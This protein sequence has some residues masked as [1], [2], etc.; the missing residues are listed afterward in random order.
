MPTFYER[1]STAKADF[2]KCKPLFSADLLTKLNKGANLGP[3]LKTFDKA[4]GYEAR[5]KAMMPVR[6]AKEVYDR[7]IRV[8]MKVIVDAKKKD[9]PAYKALEKLEKSLLSILVDADKKAQPPRPGGGTV[10]YEV[11]RSFN[12]AGSFKPKYLDLQTTRVDVVIEVDKTLDELIKNGQESLKIE[13]LG[14]VAKEELVKVGDVFAKTVAAIDDKVKD[15]NAAGRETKIKEANEALKHYAQIVQDRLN[16]AVEREWQSYLARKKYLRDFRIKCGV[17]IALGTVGVAIAVTSAAMSFGTLWMNVVAAAKGVSDLAQTIK[18]W[19]E[20][21]D[22]VYETLVKNIEA[23]NKL[24]FQREQAKKAGQGQ[25]ASKAGAAAKEVLTGILPITKNMVTSA[26]S[27]EDRAKQMLGLVSKLE[28]QADKL[29]GQLNAGVAL[30]TKLPEKQM[31]PALK[32]DAEKM[33]QT[34][35][36]LFTEISDLHRKSQNCAKFGERALM[37]VK[38][39]R[40]ND[41]WTGGLAAEAT[42][43]GTKGV[44]IYALANFALEAA[45]HGTTLLSLI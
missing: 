37:E 34:F 18:T 1:W 31:T 12:L 22:T 13:H 16:G 21:L 40:V 30:M 11:L 20:N 44:A 25:K 43:M 5:S 45:K 38:K 10:P 17:K 2:D 3:A 24:N 8:V 32:A 6:T 41:L 27:V 14:D 42:G 29:V 15:L 39:L 23:V 7:E 28:N 19:A 9:S 35:Q 4:D 36:K 26:S 33:D